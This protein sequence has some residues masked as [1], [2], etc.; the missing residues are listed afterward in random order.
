MVLI[1]VSDVAPTLDGMKLTYKK[2]TF[3][4][5]IPGGTS[6]GIL[7]TKNSWILSLHD[8]CSDFI[9]TAECSIIEGLSPEFTEEGEYVQELDKLLTQLAEVS[10]SFFFK[11]GAL[12]PVFSSNGRIFLSE[13]LKF[14]SI[15]FGLECALLSIFHKSNAL[16][17][18]NKFSQGKQ[19]ILVNGLVWMG[20]VSFM[21][22][23]IEEKLDQGYST[24]KLKVGALDFSSELKIIEG[25][26]KQLPSEKLTIRVD[27]NGAFSKENVR[28]SLYELAQ[29]E[30]HSI[31]QPI[32]VG[33]IELLRQLCHE[34]ILPIAL[35]EELIAYYSYA[36]KQ[37][38]LQTVQPQFIVLKPSLHGGIFGTQE[39]IQLAQDNGIDWWLTSALEGNIGLLAIAQ[40]AAEYDLKLPQ[41]LGTGS[42]FSNNFPSL[43]VLEN[44]YVKQA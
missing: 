21:Q 2:H 41:G 40:L 38:L 34:N 30:V 39:W 31:E 28:T 14:P 22:K 42:L 37:T 3:I 6:R 25:L 24:I 1:D 44:G 18:D 36:E 11:M 17:F 19:N 4:F 26:R 32:A 7:Q 10:S 27:A 20:D 5:K 16:I 23:Q 35:D 33:Q 29:L 13:W 43:L 9:A 8:D 15:K 12:K